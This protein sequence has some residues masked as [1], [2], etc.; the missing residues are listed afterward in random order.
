RR[1]DGAGAARVLVALSDLLRRVL[2]RSR[3]SAIPLSEEIDFITKYLEIEQTRFGDRLTTN[4]SLAPD[5]A[6][7]AIPPFLVQPLVENAVKHAVAK[8]EIP[9]GMI[10]VRAAHTGEQIRI[11]VEDN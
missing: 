6:S 1:Q 4:I 11:T 5:V 2:D 3:V 8:R 10:D 9:G 7:I